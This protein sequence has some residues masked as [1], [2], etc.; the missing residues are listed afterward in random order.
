MGKDMSKKKQLKTERGL[1]KISV[2]IPVYNVEKYLEK[3]IQS[4]LHNTYKNLQVICI[5]DGSTDNSGTILDRLSLSDS[6]LIVIHQDNRGVANARNAGLEIAEGEIISFID[7]DD[8]V[9]SR[10]FETMADCLMIKQADVVICGCKKVEESGEAEFPSYQRISY[11]RLTDRQFYNNYYA[12]H[13]VWARLYRKKILEGISFSEDVSL[14]EDTLYNLRV[15]SRLTH[16]TIYKTRDELYYY[17]QR[18]DSIIHTAVAERLIDHVEWYTA[19]KE[20]E[21]ETAGSWEWIILMHMIKMALSY[22]YTVRYIRRHDGC[23]RHANRILRGLYRDLFRLKN[24]TLIEYIMLWMMIR[25]PW[26]YRLFRIIQ[27]P[28]MLRWERMN[29]KTVL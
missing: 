28:T 16:P 1:S 5:D 8:F 29:T 11:T 27:D 14:A 25:S 9:H 17:R 26:L 18:Q 6:R 10:Y 20:S 15:V 12:R 19:N 3:C 2:I 24:N 22:R 4:V 7:A 23:N 21:H 13:M